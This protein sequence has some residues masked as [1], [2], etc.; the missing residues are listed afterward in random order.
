[1]IFLEPDEEEVTKEE[2]ADWKRDKITVMF[3]QMLDNLM[4]GYDS[5]IH[6]LLLDERGQKLHEA[7]L[8]NSARDAVREVKETPEQLITTLE[9]DDEQRSDE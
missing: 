6:N 7:A 5:K 3:Y 2:I 4:E 9:E 8:L 1:M